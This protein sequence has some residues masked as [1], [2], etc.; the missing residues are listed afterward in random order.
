LARGIVPARGILPAALVVALAAVVAGHKPHRRIRYLPA[1]GIE[2]HSEML[3]EGGTDLCGAPS[4]TTLRLAADFTGR[5]AIVV[6]GS[7]VTL[8]DFSV[9]GN[10]EVPKAP[11]GLAPYDTPFARFTR[12]N[13]VLADGVDNLRVENLR[14]RN[15]A[16][17]AILIG[18]SH[19]VT[20]DRVM[21]NDSGGRN[22]AGRNNATGGILLEEGS[23]DFAVTR[24]RLEKILGNGIWTHS[25]YTSPRNTRGLIAMN[26]IAEVGRDAI[27]VGHATDVRV[28]DN[29]A[30][31]VGYPEAAV[32]IENRAIPV[33]LD[34]AGNVEHASYTHNRLQEINGKCMDLDGFHDGEIRGN[35]CVNGGAPQ[36]YRFGNYGIVMNNANPDMQSRNIRIVENTVDGTLFG[37]IFV[38]GSGHLIA[39]NRLLHLNMA[40]CNENAARFGCYF[41]PGEPNML[42]TGIYLGRGAERPAQA[43]DNVIEDNEISGFQMATRCWASAPGILP[44]WNM[45]RRNRCR[46]E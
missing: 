37:G 19:R 3:V 33:G 38:I 25:L 21:V 1:G 24:C 40:H 41:A 22:A 26:Q 5:A 35:V 31:C 7:G 20:I 28:E 45:V 23:S 44:W 43:R 46:D 34:T 17:F 6:K 18:R 16:G 8:R 11:T 2:L 4:G 12:N 30:V 15:M 32:D 10:R 27:Q 36:S 42:R 14:F 13:G 9:E 39:R 29:S